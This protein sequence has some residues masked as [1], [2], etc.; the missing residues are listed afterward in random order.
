MRSLSVE[1]PCWR[2]NWSLIFSGALEPE[3]DRY[4]T[5]LEKRA[6]MFPDAPVTE[7]DG[8]DGAMRRIH[9]D[10]VAKCM[11]VKVEFQTLRR[12][13]RHTEFVLFSVRT[14]IEPM[15]ALEQLPSAAQ[16]LAANVR[17][18][19]QTEFRTYKGLDDERIAHSVLAFLDDCVKRS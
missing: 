13:Q 16:L 6:R 18:A 4:L 7:W 5:N 2:T 12:L 9:R 3:P 17:R 11:F 10:G 14:H 1:R 19:V 8:P 15:H